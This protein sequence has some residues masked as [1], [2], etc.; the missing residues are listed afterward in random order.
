MSASVDEDAIVKYV[1]RALGEP[2]IQVELEDDT[3]LEMIPQA[4]GVYGTYKPVEKLGQ[5]NILSG[6]QKYNLTPEQVGKGI[7]EWFKPDMM[8]GAISLE[9]FD[10]FKYH[11][12]VP[13]LDPGDYYLERV[14]WKEV[15]SV[16][17]SDDDIF[18]H[19]N[20]TDGT[21]TL[22]VTPIPS[23][24]Y[25]LVYIYV[26]DPTLRE[27]PQSDDDWIKDYV[28]AMCMEVL[29]RIRS[30]FRGV[31]GAET[32]I[33]MD[34]DELKAKGAEMRTMMEEYLKDRGQIVAPIRG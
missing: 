6:Q 3:I 14:W 15:R 23:D 32:G 19:I 10:V 13:N 31:Q 11:T 34:G 16:A 28:L 2:T 7:I 24:S 12:H 17:G 20:P 4:V 25:V 22:Y 5:I 29:G 33:E 9:E 26:V 18:I 8:Q 21:A 30:K 1:R 27:I